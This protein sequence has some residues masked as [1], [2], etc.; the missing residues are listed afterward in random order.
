MRNSIAIGPEIRPGA[1]P[2]LDRAP[3]S[4]SALS[5][6]GERLSSGQ[7][8]HHTGPG[9]IRSAASNGVSSPS[10]RATDGPSGRSS[11]FAA[12]VVAEESEELGIELVGQRTVGVPIDQGGDLPA[13]QAAVG[14][15]AHDDTFQRVTRRRSIPSDTS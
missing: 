7:T 1:K 3:A 15:L 8:V 6:R 5:E 4:T 11:T 2:P 9:A 14:R 12:D 13:P 10:S